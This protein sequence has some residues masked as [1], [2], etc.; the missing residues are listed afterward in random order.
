[1]IAAGGDHARRRRS[2]LKHDTPVAGDI[3]HGADLAEHVQRSLTA[4]VSMGAAGGPATDDGGVTVGV[5]ADAVAFLRRRRGGGRTCGSP[6][7]VRA[8]E[9]I[10]NDNA[11]IVARA[12][13][14]RVGGRGREGECQDGKY[15]CAWVPD[16]GTSL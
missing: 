7:A 6:R 10:A 4:A 12:P 1:V 5:V 16:H 8:A 14:C 13:G 2:A 9:M 15:E 11:V 3:E